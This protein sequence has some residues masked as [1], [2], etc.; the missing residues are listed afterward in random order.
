MPFYKESLELEADKQL[1]ALMADIVC[2]TG[3]PNESL[4]I[5]VGDQPP[6]A[7]LINTGTQPSPTPACTLTHLG[8]TATSPM[9]RPT[10][11]PQQP[12]SL[13][14]AVVTAAKTALLQQQSSHLLTSAATPYSVKRKHDA[15]SWYDVTHLISLVG[16]CIDFY[17]IV[18]LTILRIDD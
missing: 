2:F 17:I 14:V 5:S 10:S 6:G 3:K 12:D 7:Q 18:T 16:Y 15:V 9:Q 11:K 8:S 1:S 13:N 4:G